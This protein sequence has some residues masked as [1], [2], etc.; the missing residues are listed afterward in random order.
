MNCGKPIRDNEETLRKY[1]QEVDD[2]QENLVDQWKR[3]IEFHHV[4]IELTH[5]NA[6][7]NQF[8]QIMNVG[9]FYQ[10]NSFLMSDDR[11]E[12]QSH[13]ELIK[14]LTVLFHLYCLF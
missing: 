1:A 6:L 2:Q 13:V 3:D 4:L 5:C 12:R 14:N 7:I 10:I 8:T 11:Q 9:R